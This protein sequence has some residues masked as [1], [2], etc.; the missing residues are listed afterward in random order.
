MS[1]FA[2]WVIGGFALFVATACDV[3]ITVVEVHGD[4]A[5]PAAAPSAASPREGLTAM[6]SEAGVK[7][8]SGARFGG[9]LTSEARPEGQEP[10]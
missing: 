4:R 9:V 1:K 6:S 7:Q 2:A 3:R 8:A 5:R 10:L